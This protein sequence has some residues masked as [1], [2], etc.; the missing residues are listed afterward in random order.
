MQTMKKK[1]RQ[2]INDY[3]LQI[4]TFYDSPI[5]PRLEKLT[6]SIDMSLLNLGRELYNVHLQHPD[7]SMRRFCIL[8]GFEI[9]NRSDRFYKSLIHIH[10]HFVM[11]CGFRPEELVGINYRYLKCIAESAKGVFDT[12]TIADTIN[13]IRKQKM[14]PQ[15]IGKYIKEVRSQRRA[16]L[17]GMVKTGRNG[18]ETEKS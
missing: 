11:E 1:R 18:N 8:V 3:G 7:F 17:C 6:E 10:K 12:K 16:W 15:E 9:P 2:K 4:L 13:T 14:S 5:I